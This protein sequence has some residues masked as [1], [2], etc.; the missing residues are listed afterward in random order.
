MRRFLI[1][2]A[3]LAGTLRAESVAAQGYPFSQRGTVA[4]TVAFTRLEIEYGRPTARGR[5]LFGALVPW[6]SIWH[7]GADSATTLTLSHAVTLDGQLV[8][9]GAYSLWLIPRATGPWTLIVNGATA[10]SHTPYPG[11]ASD[12]VRLDVTPETATPV[13]TLTYSFPE[14]LRDA[15]VLRLQWGHTAVSVRARAP[16]RP[17]AEPA[18]RR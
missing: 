8:P 3:L 18:A 11:Q 16:F 2:F 17:G 15:A 12:V 9:A 7:P 4:Q 6:D 1:L 14:V 10:I 13:E 5:A